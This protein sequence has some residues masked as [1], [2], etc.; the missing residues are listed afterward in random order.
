MNDRMIRTWR[1]AALAGLLLARPI[2][3]QTRPSPAPAN[4]PATRAEAWERLRAQKR[5]HLS[6]RRPTLLERRMLTM[7]KAERPTLLNLNYKG[8]YPRVRSLASGSRLAPV[9]RFWQPDIKGSSLS[10][11]ASAAYSPVGY[12]LYDFQAG[13]L[14]HRGHEL[15]PPSTRGDDVYEL[16]ALEKSGIDR[17]IL[18][19]S[20]RYR[21]QPRDSYYGLGQD[22]LLSDRTSFL[23]QDA[24]YELVTGWQFTPRLV[25]TARL[26]YLQA[27]TTDGEDDDF[28]TISQR[29]DDTTAPGLARQPD[30]YKLAGLVLFDARDRPFNPHRGGMVALALARFD[31]RGGEEFRYGQ[32][33]L[34]AR[35]YVSLGSPQRVLAARALAVLDRAADGSRVPFYFQDALSNSHTMRGY[36]IFRF[37]AEKLL[38]LQA[39]YRWEA[40]P[41]LELAII[42]DAGRVFRP[43][44]DVSLDGIRGSMGV[45]LRVKSFDEVLLR[46][47]AAWG[48]EGG[49]FY[50]R[51]GPSF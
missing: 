1:A 8:F 33:S 9:L 39:E 23:Y 7:E 46:L 13:R 35:G 16:G 5:Q 29:F 15:P 43:D 12:E 50:V 34:D 3:S 48:T 47:D 20:L 36:P 41:A 22:T 44:E 31:D 40:V 11:Q 49:R 38:S 2:L 30:F 51:F 10:V 42:A 32:A 26:G 37:R 21:H 24:S 19:T 6:P 27:F 14:P 17:L 28:P 4:P 18:Y 25:A 45:G